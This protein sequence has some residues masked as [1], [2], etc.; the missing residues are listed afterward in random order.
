MINYR[1]QCLAKTLCPVTLGSS[2]YFSSE[3]QARPL[4]KSLLLIRAD[5]ATKAVDGVTGRGLGRALQVDR[6][7]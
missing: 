5:I 4:I 2:A 6:F 3:Q 1:H 7:G